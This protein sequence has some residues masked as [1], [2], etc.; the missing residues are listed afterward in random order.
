[1]RWIRI[2]YLYF[3]I[4]IKFPR[5]EKKNYFLIWQKIVD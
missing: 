1:M 5:K 3:Y 4:K 2:N